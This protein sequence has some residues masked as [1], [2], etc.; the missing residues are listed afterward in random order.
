M[1]WKNE[2]LEAIPAS[3]LIDVCRMLAAVYAL[4]GLLFVEYPE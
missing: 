2:R 1:S 4:V 3:A